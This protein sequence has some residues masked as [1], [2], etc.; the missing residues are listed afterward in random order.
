MMD[1]GLAAVHIKQHIDS[2]RNPRVDCRDSI[3]I[4]LKKMKTSIKLMFRASKDANKDGSLYFQVLHGRVPRQAATSCRVHS[5]EWDV[6]SGAITITDSLS[7]ERKQY[8]ANIQDKVRSLESLLWLII[9]EK[10]DGHAD[11]TAD[12]V[13]TTFKQREAC[14]SS[15]FAY[16]GSEVMRMN[17]LKRSGTAKNYKSTLNSFKNFRNS[18]D[19][20]FHDFNATVVNAYDAWLKNKGLSRNSISFYMRTL[21]TLY[22]RAI[23]DGLAEPYTKSPFASVFTGMDKTAKRAVSADI[24]SRLKSLDLTATPAQDFA[25]NIF[26]LS[27]YLRGMSFVDMAYLKRSNLRGGILTYCRQKTNQQLKILWLPEMQQI[28]DA[29]QPATGDYM[30][31]IITKED[32]TERR[33]YQNKLAS[34][35]LALKRIAKQLGESSLKSSYQS[36]HSWASIAQDSNV[37]LPVIS[38]GMGHHSLTTTQIYLSSI[39]SDKVDAANRMIINKINGRNN[40]SNV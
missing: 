38:S 1:V 37:P 19:L 36:R 16:M 5:S 4:K 24:I 32:G 21:R 20:S 22:K 15:M 26:M 39:T 11:F 9:Q 28:V 13:V 29:M 17:Q 31:P 18:A 8:L 35:N 12:D 40:A 30:L 7:T 25:R 34:V 27:F 33:Q 23:E 14:S 3:N 6:Q 10:E 2:A